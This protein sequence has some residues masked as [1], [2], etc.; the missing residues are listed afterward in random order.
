[1]H[2]MGNMYSRLHL[3]IS[4]LSSHKFYEAI[5]I[6]HVPI[7]LKNVR[8]QASRAIDRLVHTEWLTSQLTA[9][10]NIICRASAGRF[11]MCKL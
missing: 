8:T 6:V 11:L 1:M 2:C 10:N 9:I 3:A 7:N 5:K 4:Y